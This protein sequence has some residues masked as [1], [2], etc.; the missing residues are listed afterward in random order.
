[1]RT[2]PAKLRAWRERSKPLERSNLNSRTQLQRR[3]RLRRVNS[4]R[5]RKKF[6][7]QAMAC[8]NSECCVCESATDI[9]P[10]HE[11]RREHG[12]LDKDCI[13]LCVPCHTLR[14]SDRFDYD[15]ASFWHLVGVDPEQ[16]KARMRETV[17]R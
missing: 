2:D 13:P 9:I 11:P 8:R 5:M 15:P 1:M 3:K 17:N 7:T 10:H 16:V 6:G 4:K 14:H 12:G